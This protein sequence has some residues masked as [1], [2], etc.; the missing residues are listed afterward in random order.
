MSQTGDNR[1]N[2]SWRGAPGS[3]NSDGRQTKLL[4]F[5]SQFADAAKE[6]DRLLARHQELKH[7]S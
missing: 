1:E 3:G 5:G 4:D 7:S 2:S 6:F